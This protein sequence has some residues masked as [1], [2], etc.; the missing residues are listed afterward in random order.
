MLHIFLLF[1]CIPTPVKYYGSRLGSP[2]TSTTIGI[3]G[4]LGILGMPN[5]TGWALFFP[6]LPTRKAN[7]TSRKKQNSIPSNPLIRP[8]LHPSF[9]GTEPGL[10]SGLCGA[11]V[12]TSPLLRRDGASTEAPHNPPHD[13]I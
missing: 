9:V 1:E 13:N 7:T 3:L 10:M 4:I 2:E 6:T 11:S 5:A 12:L 8:D